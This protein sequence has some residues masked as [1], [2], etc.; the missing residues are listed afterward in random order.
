LLTI[1]S[2]IYKNNKRKHQWASR[3]TK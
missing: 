1:Y 2:I 3:L